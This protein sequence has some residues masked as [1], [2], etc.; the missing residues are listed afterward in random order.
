[1]KPPA[2]RRVLIVE[3]HE[4]AR[5]MMSDLFEMWGHDVSTSSNGREAMARMSDWQP[6]IAFIDIGLPDMDG[7]ELGRQIRANPAGNAVYL[8]AL[9]GFGL[10]AVRDQI[11]AAGFD[12]H[13]IKPADPER[14]KALVDNLGSR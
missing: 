6:E 5:S 3:D 7:C 14:L 12:E 9:T 8:V 11:N 13:L 10:P 1:M 2:A 4:D